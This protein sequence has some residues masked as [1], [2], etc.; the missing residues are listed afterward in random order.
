MDGVIFHSGYDL[1][2]DTFKGQ[3]MAYVVRSVSTWPDGRKDLVLMSANSDA[4][5]TQ[6]IDEARKRGEIQ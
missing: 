1:A 2:S 4:E 3:S 6:K 5:L